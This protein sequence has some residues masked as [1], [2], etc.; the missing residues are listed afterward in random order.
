MLLISVRNGNLVVEKNGGCCVELFLLV[1]VE[2]AVELTRLVTDAVL[3]PLITAL[4]R[5]KLE[6]LA[7]GLVVKLE[8]EAPSEELAT[9]ELLMRLVGMLFIK[10]CKLAVVIEVG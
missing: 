10:G 8:L 1:M 9:V 7:I 2:L 4:A 6:L 5:T 3:V